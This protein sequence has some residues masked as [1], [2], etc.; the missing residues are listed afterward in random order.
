MI[1]LGTKHFT[2]V[3]KVEMKSYII[4]RIKQKNETEKLKKKKVQILSSAYASKIKITQNYV[5]LDIVF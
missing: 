1:D 4:Q 2:A 5:E 3:P